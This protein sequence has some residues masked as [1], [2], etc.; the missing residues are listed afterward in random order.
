M[1]RNEPQI[2]CLEKM[3]GK[4]L[5]F[6]TDRRTPL[7]FLMAGLFAV[8]LACRVS[9]ENPIPANLLNMKKAAVW[10]DGKAAQAGKGEIKDGKI[11]FSLADYPKASIYLG[12]II[13]PAELQSDTPYRLTMK[14]TSNR[15]AK[16][17][18][19]YI[20]SKAPYTSYAAQNITLK[21]G[22]N[23]YSIVFTPKMADGKYESPRSLHFLIGEFKNTTIVIS[24][25]T[26]TKGENVRSTAAGK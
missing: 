12:Q 2:H 15:E 3:P 19:R 20:L 26:L 13:I 9:A 14:I 1:K 22:T 5:Q 7:L 8:L 6:R 11:L 10:F 16:L 25:M 24:D 23:D 21:N 4:I 18:F 17:P